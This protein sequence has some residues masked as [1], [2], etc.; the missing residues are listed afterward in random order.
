LSQW[1]AE[2]PDL[3]PPPI[4]GVLTHVDLLSPALEWAPPYD[5]RHPKKPKEQNIHDAARAARQQ[6]GERLVNL[7]PVC[8]QQGKA[9][10]VEEELLP[11][12]AAQLEEARGIALLRCLKAE[13]DREK[14]RKVFQ[15]MYQ[16]GKAAGW[17]AWEMLT[18][19]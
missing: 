16:A 10:G 1:F 12:I 2:R 8:T 7:V 4:I 15:Q 17:I 5:W 11:A 13:A 19:K 3:K 9:W 6:L 14:V 18:R